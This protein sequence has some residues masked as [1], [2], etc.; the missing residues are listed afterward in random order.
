MEEPGDDIVPPEAV[1]NSSESES[2]NDSCGCGCSGSDSDCSRESGVA[3]AQLS[4]L[5]LRQAELNVL[6][7]SGILGPTLSPH[8]SDYASSDPASHHHQEHH[9]QH[10]Q[11]QQKQHGFWRRSRALA[12][13][14]TLVTLVRYPLHTSTMYTQYSGQ[15]TQQSLL[16]LAR[17]APVGTLAQW[18]GGSH[19]GVVGSVVRTLMPNEATS[20]WGMLVGVGLHYCA[21]GVL[22]GAFRQSVV[23]RLLAAQGAKSL[24]FAD[25]VRP[26]MHW[27]RDRLLLRGP[28]GA[29]LALYLRD[30]AGNALQAG[31]ALGATRLL[32]SSPAVRAYGAI[33][34]RQRMRRRQ[35][36][37]RPLRPEDVVFASDPMVA[38]PSE[39]LARG[40]ELLIY[41]QAVA[42]LLAA[43]ATRLAFYPVDSVVVRL[44]ADE[45]GLTQCG[46]AGFFACLGAVGW[47]PLY[48]GWVRT[49]VAEASLAWLAAEVAHYL[50]R[51]AWVA[52]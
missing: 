3:A 42:S 25:A 44:M 7:R 26:I 10:Q 13:A 23:V 49:A 16:R 20:A 4:R 11:Q 30:V 32:T 41:T 28:R 39:A 43:V 52:M 9:Q 34:R 29:V 51:S 17:T 27:V 5:E 14:Q 21:F 19:L 18:A 24:S 50:C 47:R 6:Q 33:G 40:G 46:Y 45:A 35:Q 38:P 36:Q 1:S 15:T 8:A 31:L 12:V 48:A 22:Y 2:D 37:Q